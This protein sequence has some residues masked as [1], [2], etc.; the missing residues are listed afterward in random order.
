MFSHAALPPLINLNLLLQRSDLLP[1][2]KQLLSRFAFPELVRKF[3]NCYVTIAQIKKE[4]F[5]DENILDKSKIFFG[6]LLCSKLNELLDKGDISE[7]DFDIFYKSVLKFPRTSFI[8]T[9]NNFPFQDE[10]LQHTRFVN[11][12]N[13]KCEV[14]F[15]LLRSFSYIDFSHQDLCQL[16]A[17]FL[18]LQSIT[19][20]DMSEEV[21]KETAIHYGDEEHAVFYRIDVLCYQVPVDKNFIACSTS[22]EWCYASF[23]A[24]QKSRFFQVSRNIWP[25]SERL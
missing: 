11:F 16:G 24:T 10:F 17:E 7:W 4:V 14:F 13:Q 20:D 23:T 25:H 18:T 5:K 9:I 19:L 15:S 21:L 1:V 6:F 2:L 8:Y 12:Y 3:T 22:C